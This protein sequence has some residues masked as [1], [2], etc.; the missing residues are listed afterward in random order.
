[1]EFLNAEGGQ[2][3]AVHSGDPLRLRLHYECQRDIPA[4]Y[5]G[6]KIV[7][8]LGVLLSNVN[9]WSTSQGVPLAAQGQDFIELE[10]DSLNL[11]PGTYYLGLW[12][13]SLDEYHDVL[14][15]VAKLDVEPSDFYGTGRGIEARFGL[16]F[17]PF[18]WNHSTHS[19]GRPA[20][21][22][23]KVLPSTQLPNCA[24]ISSTGSSPTASES[25]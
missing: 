12:T 1:M 9:T 4:L 17:F 6:L 21:G 18:R 13:S 25:F 15:N 22:S 24:D 20:F 7:S 11:M 3:H 23:G 19:R 10:I 8:N 16:M 14:D 2:V 5:F